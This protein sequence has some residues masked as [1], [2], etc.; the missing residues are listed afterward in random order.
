MADGASRH[1]LVNIFIHFGPKEV[2]V[3]DVHGLV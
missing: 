2:L 3:E 1:N